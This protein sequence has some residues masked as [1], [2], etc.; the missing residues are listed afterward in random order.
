MELI[1]ILS[2]K[3][4]IDYY[5]ISV[6]SSST[7][8][9]V[10]LL[11]MI[12]GEWQKCIGIEVKS[13]TSGVFYLSKQKEQSEFYKE[14]LNEYGMVT[15]Y[16]MRLVKQRPGVKIIKEELWRFF[17]LDDTDVKMVWVDGMTL[18]EFIEEIIQS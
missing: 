14:K 13:T 11:E 9:D 10:I 16:A 6:G 12:P 3:L 1:G 15:C 17:W 7:I 18:D 4:P 2:N 8:W 5:P